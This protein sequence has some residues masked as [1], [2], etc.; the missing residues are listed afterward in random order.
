[1]QE[2]ARGSARPF[3][4]RD[5]RSLTVVLATHD[6]AIAATCDTVVRVRDGLIDNP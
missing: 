5:Q 2:R 4:L 3:G 6:P 1:M